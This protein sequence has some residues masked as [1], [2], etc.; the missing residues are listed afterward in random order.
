MEA[1]EIRVKGLIH[2]KKIQ[3]RIEKLSK[4]KVDLVSPQGKIKETTATEKIVKVDT[5]EVSVNCLMKLFFIEL[6]H[7]RKKIMK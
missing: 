4:K 3:E 6:L 2:A 5:K 1:G 7:N